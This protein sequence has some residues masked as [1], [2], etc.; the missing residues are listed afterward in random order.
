MYDFKKSFTPEAIEVLETYEW[1]GNV[2][3]LQNIVER[4][5][6]LCEDD[7]I[8]R[9]HALKFLYGEVQER[10]NTLRVL[11]IIPM[12]EAVEELEA[13]LIEKGMKK[14]HTAA[15]LSKILGVSPAT[16]S[17]RMKKLKN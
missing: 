16:I 11:D 6:L 15:K 12:K 8:S 4:L 10:K 1:P 2:R 3:E 17:R 13:Q 7:W 5:I 9:E 14:Y